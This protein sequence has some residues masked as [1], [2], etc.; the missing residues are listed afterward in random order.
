MNPEERVQKNQSIYCRITKINPEKFSIDAICKTS[1][2]EDKENELKPRKDDYY[3]NEAEEQDKVKNAAE[4]KKAQAKQSYVKRVIVHP[5]FKNIDHKRA[6]K[7]L[8]NLERDNSD[9]QD[10]EY[11]QG[12][13][14]IRPSSKVRILFTCICLYYEACNYYKSFTYKSDFLEFSSFAISKIFSLK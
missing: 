12:D 13:C 1:A 8:D 4:R 3:D 7:I 6:E 14:I 11:Q 9:S 2:L 10:L 5:N